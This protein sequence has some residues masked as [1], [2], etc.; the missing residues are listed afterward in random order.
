MK[1]VL[2]FGD[3]NTWGYDVTTYDP[4]L[5]SGQRLPKEERWTGIAAGLLGPDYELIVD[6]LNGRTNVGDDPFFP[7]HV[8]IKH[9][10]TALDAHAPLDLVVLKLGCNELKSFFNLSAGMI[11][12]GFEKLVAEAEKPYYNYPA[13]KILI[14]SPAPTHPK[15][16]EMI[17]GFNFGPGAYEKSLKFG[18]L[19]GDIARR[20]GCGYINC[21]DLNF[22][23]NELDGLHYSKADHAKLGPVAAEKI[24]EMLA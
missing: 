24:R 10:C 7:D 13:P 18:A 9:L 23:I 15:I 22:E 1:R 21:A 12:F 2:I 20:H 11:A 8:G 16:S 14:I 17:F 3:S 4:A 6:A 5:G 19:Y